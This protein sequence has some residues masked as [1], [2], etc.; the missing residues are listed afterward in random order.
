M[1]SDLHQFRGPEDWQGHYDEPVKLQGWSGDWWVA[2]AGICFQRP[3]FLLLRAW[4]AGGLS[5]TLPETGSI[6]IYIFCLL[7][8]NLVT[9]M[10]KRWEFLKRHRTCTLATSCHYNEVHQRRGDWWWLMVSEISAR[11]HW[12]CFWVCSKAIHH[13]RGAE[14]NTV[15]HFMVVGKQGLRPRLTFQEHVPSD[16]L[17]VTGPQFLLVTI[18]Q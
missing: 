1:P 5:S 4:E 6:F 10:Q 2:V 9:L 17:P 18:S 8:P 14:R 3:L 11:Q 15:D 12:L 7:S 13:S 16:F